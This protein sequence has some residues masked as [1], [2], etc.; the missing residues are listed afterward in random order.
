MSNINLRDFYPEIYKKDTFI[1]VKEEVKDL[2][3]K[4]KKDE[5]AFLRKMYRYD[6][7]YSLDR[8][9]GIELEELERMLT[10]EEIVEKQILKEKVYAAISDLPEKQA[11]RIYAYFYLGLSMTEIA[12]TE[13]VTKARISQSIKYGLRNLS[14]KLKKFY[15]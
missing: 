10:P 13:G 11:K 1:E 3:L 2:L 6:A 15:E 5:N 9:D 14:N 8:E 4:F 7:F 12:R